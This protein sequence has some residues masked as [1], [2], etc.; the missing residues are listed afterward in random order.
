LKITGLRAA[1]SN[2]LLEQWFLT[3]VQCSPW[4]WTEPFQRFYKGP[5]NHKNSANIFVIFYN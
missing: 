4:G 2:V 1:Q 3:R 5:Q